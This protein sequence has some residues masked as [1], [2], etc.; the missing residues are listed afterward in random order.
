MAVTRLA[1]IPVASERF[2]ANSRFQAMDLAGI[3]H[4]SDKKTINER[5]WYKHTLIC[6]HIH[7]GK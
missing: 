2:E 1:S 5:K 3:F 7:I 4:L 6:I